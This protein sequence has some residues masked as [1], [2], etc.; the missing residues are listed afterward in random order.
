MSHQTTVLRTLLRLLPPWPG[1]RFYVPSPM[2]DPF[3]ARAPRGPR[4]PDFVAA[5]GPSLEKISSGIVV[6][7]FM[8][9][10]NTIT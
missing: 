3:M 9:P 1:L 2:Q 6:S 4:Y 10:G 5:Q 7:L 8:P